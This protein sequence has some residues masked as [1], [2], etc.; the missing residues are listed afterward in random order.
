LQKAVQRARRGDGPMLVE[1]H[2]Y[3]MQA[4]TNA[5]DDTRYRAREEVQA[6]EARDPLRRMAAHLRATGM[7]DDARQSELDAGA[8]AIAAELRTALSTDTEPDPEDLFR[9]VTAA[10]SPQL[11]EQ[12]HLLRDELERTDSAPTDFERNLGGAR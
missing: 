2:T 4:H 1:A 6:W 5:D 8:D 10:R 11:T 12:W 9:F 7:L 3:R